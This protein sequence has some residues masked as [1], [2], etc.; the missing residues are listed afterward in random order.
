MDA[1]IY[2]GTGGV[3]ISHANHDQKKKGP[4]AAS[5]KK[6]C[7]IYAMGPPLKPLSDQLKIFC[8]QFGDIGK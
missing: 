5:P 6:I 4:N 1:L 7:A 3:S 2:L 8:S